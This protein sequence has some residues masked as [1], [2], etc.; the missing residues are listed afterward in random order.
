MYDSCYDN[1]EEGYAHGYAGKAKNMAAYAKYYHETLKYNVLM[2]DARG[3][4][5][6]GIILD[7]VG[8][9]ARIICNGLII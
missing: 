4:V 9:S 6:K 8:L 1:L 5:A 7:L 2:P 3:H